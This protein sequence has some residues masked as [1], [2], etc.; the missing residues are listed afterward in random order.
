MT[1]IANLFFYVLILTNIFPTSTALDIKECQQTG[2]HTAAEIIKVA[3]FV[4]CCSSPTRRYLSLLQ[5]S[6]G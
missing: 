6:K 2:D 5:L 3:A 1:T 4:H